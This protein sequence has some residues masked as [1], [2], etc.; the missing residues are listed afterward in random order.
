MS[1]KYNRRE[2]LKNIALGSGVL[3]LGGIM[4]SFYAINSVDKKEVFQIK[5]ILTTQ[6]TGGLIRIS[7]WKNLQWNAR[8]WDFRELIC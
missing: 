5:K 2:V 3:S 8:K 4:S 1:S 6:S 7:H